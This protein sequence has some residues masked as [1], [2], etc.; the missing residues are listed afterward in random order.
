[1]SGTRSRFPKAPATEAILVS[2]GQPSDPEPAEAALAALADRVAGHLPDWRIRSATLAAAG[3]FEDV[4][5]T[6]RATPAVL[7]VFMTEGWFTRQALPARIGDTPA[8]VLH[9]L[10]SDPNLPSLAARAITAEAT[11]Q[12]WNMR[13]VEILIAAHGSNRGPVP[14]QCTR[15][16]AHDLAQILPCRQLRIGFLEQTPELDAVAAQTGH[17]AICLPFFAASGE[18]VTEDVPDALR[19]GGFAGVT[20]PAVGLMDQIPLIAAHMLRSATS[21]GQAA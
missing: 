19:A 17:P 9:P 13:D 20:L 4:L 15:R 21:H 18:H 10:G 11:G 16:F 8:N 5:G 14:A 1:M 12:G 3:R 2:H 6:A 7:P